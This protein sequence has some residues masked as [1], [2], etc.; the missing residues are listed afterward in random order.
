MYNVIILKPLYKKAVQD[1]LPWRSCCLTKPSP[2]ITCLKIFF[3]FFNPFKI[4]ILLLIV[5][6]VDIGTTRYTKSK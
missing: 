3:H 6:D 1:T 5:A 4:Y 2:Y